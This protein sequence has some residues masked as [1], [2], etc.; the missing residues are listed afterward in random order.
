[1]K[2]LCDRE[3]LREALGLVNSTIPTKSTRPAIENVCLVATDD[4]LELV[5]TDLEV[6]IRFRIDDVKVEEAGTA[7]V[8]GRVSADFV[9]DLTGETVELESRDDKL[10]IRSGAD[11]CELPTADPDEYPVV[12]RFDDEGALPIQGA[13][14]TALV[15]RTAFAAAK[16]QGRYAMH[17]ILTLV[18]DQVLRMVATDGRRLAVAASPIDSPAGPPRKAIVPTKGMQ[19]FC[20]VITDPLEQVHVHFGTNQIGLRTK[21]A[22]IFARLID[23]DFPRYAAVIPNDVQHRMEADAELLA[24][25][26]KLVSN[27]TSQ[28]AR[29]VKLALSAGKLEVFGRSAAAGEAAAELEVDYR[30]DG[31]EIAFNPDFLM[32]GLRNCE[33]ELVALEFNER[34]SPGKFTLGESYVYVVMPITVDA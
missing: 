20:R 15:G 21:H 4:A 14:F 9:R 34:T 24:R 19:A 3:R 7:L 5:G 17:G 6:A 16:E 33:N 22:E 11:H 31:A 27:V 28:D 13:S 25:K 32:D 8:S 18:E 29:A 10:H 2:V 23:G 26:L 30:G 1:M 12:A